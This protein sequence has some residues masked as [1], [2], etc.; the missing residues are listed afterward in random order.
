L[1]ANS[2]QAVKAYETVFAGMADHIAK[3]IRTDATN[4]SDTDGAIRLIT[5]YTH[6]YLRA[7][8]AIALQHYRKDMR[9]TILKKIL[10]LAQTLKPQVSAAN[11]TQ[12]V[13]SVAAFDKTDV[14]VVGKKGEWFLNRPVGAATERPVYNIPEFQTPEFRAKNIITWDEA[15]EQ[16]EKDAKELDERS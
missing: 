8:Y 3:T 10:S 16:L 13:E 12:S 15:R 7:F 11:I 4:I 14:R 2:L 9:D 6:S 5:D 1:P